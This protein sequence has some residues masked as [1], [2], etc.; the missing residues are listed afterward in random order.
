M[1]NNIN[2]YIKIETKKSG[3][4]QNEITNVHLARSQQF[5]AKL[6]QTFFYAFRRET[7]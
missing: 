2:K 7:S 6:L 3:L 1:N 4:I 5:S